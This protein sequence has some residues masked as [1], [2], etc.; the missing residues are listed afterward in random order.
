M[1]RIKKLKNSRTQIKKLLGWVG[2]GEGPITIGP[3]ITRNVIGPII[4]FTKIHCF[5]DSPAGE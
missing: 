1:G 3:I 5:H 4:V 2:R